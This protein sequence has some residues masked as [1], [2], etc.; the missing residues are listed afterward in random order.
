MKAQG[1]PLFQTKQFILNNFSSS[2]YPSRSD[3]YC[4]Y[5]P[6]CGFQQLYK[7]CL[8]Y[9]IFYVCSFQTSFHASFQLLY[10]LQNKQ[11]ES[12]NFL[13]LIIS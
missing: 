2:D 9:V 1:L 4:F 11:N 13:S 5:V 12:I 10:D 6:S 8:F 7:I 3:N